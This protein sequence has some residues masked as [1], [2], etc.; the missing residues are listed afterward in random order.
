MVQI[1]K[2]LKQ[3]GVKAVNYKNVKYEGLGY[4]RECD[5]LRGFFTKDGH[6]QVGELINIANNSA[7][8]EDVLKLKMRLL[9]MKEEEIEEYLLNTFFA[10]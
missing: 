5:R 6:I 10:K 9:G 4:S 7:S 1:V 3:Y 8:S 2:R